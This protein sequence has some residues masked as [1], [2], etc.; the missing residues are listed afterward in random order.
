MNFDF[1]Y[2][3]KPPNFVYN[4]IHKEKIDFTLR[5]WMKFTNVDGEYLNARSQCLIEL[6]R[7]FNELEVEVARDEILYLDRP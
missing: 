3:A 6:S 4:E 1:L 2:E 7:L 5:V